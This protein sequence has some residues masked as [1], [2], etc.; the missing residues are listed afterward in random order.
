MITSREASRGPMSEVFLDTAYVIALAAPRDH[1]HDRAVQIAE[2][3]EAAST[4]LVTTQA[5]LLEIGNALAR[6]QHRR[7]A[8]ELLRTLTA[9]PNVEI[10]PISDT[11]YERAFRLYGD[12]PDKEWGLTDCL[13]FVVMQERGIT[14]ALTTDHHFQQTGF[15]IWLADALPS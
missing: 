15:H 5:V 1:F 7:I 12:R 8:V 3:L 14:E 11:L 6:L 4:R 9:D 10:I 13:S 2:Q